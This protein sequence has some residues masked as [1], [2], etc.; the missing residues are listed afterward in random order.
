MIKQNIKKIVLIYSTAVFL[1]KYQ[2]AEALDAYKLQ[3]P[4]GGKI[5]DVQTIITLF[6]DWVIN[7]GIV[8]VVLAFMYTGFQ[9][10]TARGNPEAIQKAKTSFLW[11]VVG[12]LVLVAAKVL[13]E[14]IKNTLREAGVDLN[15][16]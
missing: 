15:P 6:V 9:F 11:T 16:S 13:V 3:D 4:L 8:A 1:I 5:P 10:V 2:T 7:L 14:V 12:T